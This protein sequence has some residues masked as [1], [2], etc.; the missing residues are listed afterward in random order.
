MTRKTAFS[1]PGTSEDA[2]MT[3]SP[4]PTSTGWVR[5]AMRPSAAMGSPWLPVLMSTIWSSG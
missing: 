1:L 5:L 2:R 4:S 3:M